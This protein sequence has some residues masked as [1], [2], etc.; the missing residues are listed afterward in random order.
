MAVNKA[1]LLSVQPN[2]YS[3]GDLG[4]LAGYYDNN[5]LIEPYSDSVDIT[6]AESVEAIR[7]LIVAK[8]LG[9]AA[10]MEYPITEESEVILAVLAS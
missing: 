5:T 4:F 8:I 7:D 3:S 9:Y 1:I 6:S 10:T 2:P